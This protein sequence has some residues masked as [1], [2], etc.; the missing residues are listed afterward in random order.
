MVVK[1]AEGLMGRV[2]LVIYA[3]VRITGVTDH[4]REIAK[5]GHLFSRA[6]MDGHIK[7][8]EKMHRVELRQDFGLSNTDFQTCTLI[9]FHKSN[10]GIITVTLNYMH[11][12]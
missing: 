10:S 9:C 5:S 4:G 3:V 8:L 2:N 6:A 11:C 12:T 7:R 1:F